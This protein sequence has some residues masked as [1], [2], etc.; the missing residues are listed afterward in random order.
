MHDR[1]LT[2][3][4]EV[5]NWGSKLINFVRRVL[6]RFVSVLDT[7]VYRNLAYHTKIY[8]NFNDN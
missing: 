6:F 8:E 2:N 1:N 7:Q 3:F 4:Y 5:L